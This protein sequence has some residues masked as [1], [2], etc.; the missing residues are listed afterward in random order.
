MNKIKIFLVIAFIALVFSIIL[1]FPLVL[2]INSSYSDKNDYA[3][4][5][6]IMSENNNSFASGRIFDAAKYSLSSQFYPFSYSR[7]TFD[8]SLTPTIIFGILYKIFDNTVLS[9]N[10]FAILTLILNFIVS[11]FIFRYFFRDFKAALIGAF[12]YSFNP[13]V[14]SKFP[15]QLMLLQRYF[16]LLIFLFAYKTFQKPN[17]KNFFLLTLSITLN[18]LIT[19]YFQT[20]MLLVLPLFVLPFIIRNLL[21]KNIRYFLN[22]L[23]MTIIALPFLLFILYID[24]PYFQFSKM[25]GIGRSISET[26]YFSTRLT[27]CF[28]STPDNLLYGNLVKS[29]EKSRE[30]KDIGNS[31]NY[32]E[33]TLFLNIIPSLLFIVGL[34]A[35]FRKS[36]V[37]KNRA[38]SVGFVIVLIF[39]F[40]MMWG[41]YL[42]INNSYSETLK[43]PYYYLYQL[44]P[45][46]KSTRVPT[47]YEIILYIPFA[48]F[49]GFGAKYIL[50]RFTNKGNI[51]FV[52]IIFFLILENLSV[53]TYKEFSSIQNKVSLYKKKNPQIVD[54]LKNK[55]TVHFP[56]FISL[57]D[58]FYDETRYLTWQ[59][60]THELLL[61]SLSYLPPD[62]IN[63]LNSTGNRLNENTFKSLE[64]MEVDY[65][66]IHKDYYQKDFGDLF[67]LYFQ[68]TDPELSK[69]AV[70]ED[71]QTLIIDLSK[72]SFDLQ[73]CNL[74]DDF[75][76]KLQISPYSIINQPISANLTLVNKK[77]CYF[78]S[79]LKKRYL[80]ADIYVNNSKLNT[81]YFKIP[82]LITP[83]EKIILSETLN[84]NTNGYQNFGKGNINI[85]T[86]IPFLN[87]S[88]SLNIYIDE[89]I[90][91]YPGKEMFSKANSLSPGKM[92]YKIDQVK[93]QKKDNYMTIDAVILNDGDSVW[94]G[95]VNTENIDN[96]GAVYLIS[97]F[98]NSEKKPVFADIN[99]PLFFTCTTQL[100]I[101]PNDKV[102]YFCTFNLNESLTDQIKYVKLYPIVNSNNALS[103][104][105]FIYEIK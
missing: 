95:Y 4:N 33:H 30:P 21:A 5:G 105:P 93:I 52:I 71:P 61:N 103:G 86:S 36:D 31:F 104:E 11:F 58:R 65:V 101:M 69:N 84:Y 80:Q 27:D 2:K 43:L 83:Y 59:T 26:A 68:K 8:I 78:F 90:S 73:K 76:I 34:Y 44:L 16:F 94:L 40:V 102:N 96:S 48:F 14:F 42:R 25:E 64:A 54:L 99:K 45:F 82:F 47:R 70:L 72:Y 12:I 19:L 18:A 87:I 20:Y 3:V 50:K 88:S 60:N 39:S 23:K 13:L 46:L 28:T 98:Y 63:F 89:S 100:N 38:L 53:K 37:K 10:I 1:T 81:K 66:I 9:T 35:L 55:K 32:Y 75:D 49:A 6:Y 15:E 85:R 7:A 97:E 77:N 92:H 67:S 91:L 74:R 22:L 51:I 57:T 62:W 17:F 79:N 56:S 29:I 41:P 24:F